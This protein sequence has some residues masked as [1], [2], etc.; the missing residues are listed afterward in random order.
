[1]LMIVNEF[2]EKF[3]LIV[4]VTSVTDLL[5]MTSEKGYCV[6]ALRIVRLVYHFKILR[7]TLRLFLYILR[8]LSGS[9][10]MT[11]MTCTRV[12]LPVGQIKE[13]LIS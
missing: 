9:Q 7:E 3:P 13:T 4:Y 1:M 12:Q 11:M 10:W 6:S 5:T 2:E 8:W